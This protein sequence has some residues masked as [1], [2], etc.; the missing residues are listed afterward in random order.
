VTFLPMKGET[1]VAR[2]GAPGEHFAELLEEAAP[3]KRRAR[4]KRNALKPRQSLPDHES[5]QLG[6]TFGV[7]CQYAKVSDPV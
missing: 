2:N 5:D 6:G 1:L 3:L 7:Q 4:V